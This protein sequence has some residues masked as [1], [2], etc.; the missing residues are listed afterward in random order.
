MEC[1]CSYNKGESV[2]YPDSP[3]KQSLQ[4]KQPLQDHTVIGPGHVLRHVGFGGPIIKVGLILV[5]SIVTLQ[6]YY[7]A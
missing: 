4:P 3:G 5:I 6:K 1:S 7:G 2:F